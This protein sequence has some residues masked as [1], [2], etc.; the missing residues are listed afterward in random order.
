MDED[1]FTT[2]GVNKSIE[3]GFDIA[4]LYNV[5]SGGEYTIYAQGA[6]PY[7]EL[8]STELDG[9]ALAY[10]SN[11]LTITVD[12][13]EAATVKLV[14][15]A[16][17]ERLQRRS[18][19]TAVSSDC[20]GSKEAATRAALVGCSKIAAVAAEAALNGSDAKYVPIRYTWTFSAP[21]PVKR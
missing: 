17:R 14:S 3:V 12:G 2:F 5:R 20:S 13:S 21:I 6:I 15:E 9:G 7:A 19:E 1:A 8:G 11:P 10:S 4:E 18:A 16:V